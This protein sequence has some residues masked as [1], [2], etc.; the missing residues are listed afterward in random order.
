MKTF[1][2]LTFEQYINILK[3]DRNLTKIEYVANCISIIYDLDIEKVYDLHI[4]EYKD[5]AKNVN[6]LLNTQLSTEFEKKLIDEENNLELNFILYKAENMNVRKYL[7]FESYL[8]DNN[9]NNLDKI[10]FELYDCNGID[11]AELD[12]NTAQKFEKFILS[13]KISKIYGA[14]VFFYLFGIHSLKIS[15]DFTMLDMTLNAMQAIKQTI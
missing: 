6:E 1:N 14:F 10:M 9:Y 3:L 7:V 4:N 8:K 15:Q 11:Y 12:F 5:Y 13:Q 2:D